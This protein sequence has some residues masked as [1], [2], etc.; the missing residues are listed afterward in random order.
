MDNVED[1]VEM[2]G[3]FSV[4]DI[5]YTFFSLERTKNK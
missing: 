5:S 4:S 3:L 1:L 2:P